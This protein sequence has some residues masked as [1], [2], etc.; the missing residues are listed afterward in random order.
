MAK[1]AQTQIIP[2]QEDCHGP[3]LVSSS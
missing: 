2:L 3:L 1:T